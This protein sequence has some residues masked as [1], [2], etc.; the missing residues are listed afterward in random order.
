MG[1]IEKSRERGNGAFQEEPDPITTRRIGVRKNGAKTEN[2]GRSKRRTS[3]KEEEE[4][5]R[6]ATDESVASEAMGEEVVVVAVTEIA[7]GVG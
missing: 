5:V 6:G 2:G 7:A 3:K 1:R 4:G